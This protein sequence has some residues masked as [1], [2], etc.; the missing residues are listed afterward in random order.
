MMGWLWPFAAPTGL[1]GLIILLLCIPLD[2]VLQFHA[3]EKAPFRAKFVLLFRLI[4][5]EIKGNSVKIGR[6]EKGGKK[7]ETKRIL[8]I[9]QTE[10]LLRQLKNVFPDVLRC[11]TFKDL[12]VDLRL[13]LEDPADTGLLFAWIGTASSS[14]HPFINRPITIQPYFSEG[15]V[16]EGRSFV[17]I[18]CRPI[19]LLPPLARFVFSVPALR[20]LKGLLVNRWRRKK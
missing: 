20:A 2:L 12:D 8:R 17:S 19:Q 3:N 7:I 14:F 18:R 9:L 10:G 4:H 1:V 11:F 16:I 5:L 13:G 6:S 15:P